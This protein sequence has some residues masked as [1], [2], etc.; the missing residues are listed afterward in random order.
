MGKGRTFANEANEI[1]YQTE[2]NNENYSLGSQQ[3]SYNL[4]SVHFSD[5]SGIGNFSQSGQ[6]SKFVKL[7]GSTIQGNFGF[8]Q[9]TILLDVGTSTINLNNDSTGTA[10][11]VISQDRIVSLS[12]GSTSD[13][14]TITGAQRPGQ[15]VTLY[16]IFSNTITI[17]NDAGATVNTIVTPGAVDFS[18]SGHGVVTLVFDISLAQWRIEGNLG[19][20]GGTGSQTPWIQNIDGA[21]FTLTDA[22]NISIKNTQTDGLEGTLT[23]ER[24]DTTPTN[25]DILG[26]VLFKGP[27]SG[28]TIQTWASIDATYEDVTAGLKQGQFTIRVQKDNS[29]LPIID[30]TGDDATFRFSSGVDVIRANANGSKELGTASFFWDDVFSETFTLR[31]S[32]GNT[33]GSARTVYADGTTMVFN[34]PSGGFT[35]SVNNAIFSLLTNGELEVR[36]VLVDGPTL[37][38]RN[39][40]QTPTNNDTAATILFTG[41][42]SALAEAT[43][44]SF[45]VEMDVVTAGLKQAD[46]V[47]KAQQNNTL[48]TWMNFL[49]SLDKINIFSNLDAN[50][51]DVL[52]MGGETINALTA[53]AT[54]DGAADF[55]MTYDASTTS[56]KKVLLDDLPGGGA[57]GANTAL[58]NLASVAVNTNINMGTNSLTFTAANTSF[59]SATTSN[60]IFDVPSGDGYQFQINNSNTLEILANGDLQ[61]NGK[62]IFGIVDL[63]FQTTGIDI[64]SSA[65]GLL[66][67]VP[68]GDSHIWEINSTQVL[69]ISA[70]Q[71]IIGSAVNTV[72]F[73]TADLTNVDDIAFADGHNILSTTVGLE[74]NVAASDDRIDFEVA[75][76]NLV[77]RILNDQIDV[78]QDFDMGN[79]VTVDWASTQSTVGSAGGAS[80]L[81]A[82]PTG[83]VI[84]KVNGVEKVIPFYD[85]T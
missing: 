56:L 17:K 81:P 25:S 66:Y 16:N 8:V 3:N 53:D 4:G 1:V 57:P 28:A 41:E 64:E 62:D 78:S 82:T 69:N 77:L 60:M 76:G 7:K 12:A 39:N 47:F 80:A 58:S 29:L 65:S 43:Y 15:R 70:S 9:Q 59:I 45:N 24:N 84:I 11:A 50:G 71:M 48:K 61:I 33:S 26:E 10:L 52:D 21:G 63:S 79:G 74:F 35:H 20:G 51:R 5:Q 49:G 22:G 18:L 27:D 6:N 30:Y 85:K 83:Y 46:M 75:S 36:T 2:S 68:S 13:L 37:R 55:V 44:G 72:N 73:Q 54:P 19:S 14:T 67:Q 34:M 31:G 38:L 23:L 32:G 40:D 42:D